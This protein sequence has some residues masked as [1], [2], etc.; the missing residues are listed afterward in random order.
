MD[1]DLEE[2]HRA[3]VVQNRHWPAADARGH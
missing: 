3:V 1:A 2:P